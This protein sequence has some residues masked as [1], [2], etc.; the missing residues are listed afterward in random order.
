[1]IS[2]QNGEPLQEVIVGSISKETEA[3]VQTLPGQ[4]HGLS[5]GDVITF[6]Y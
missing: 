2:D 1:M 3:V 6:R 5:N 4:R